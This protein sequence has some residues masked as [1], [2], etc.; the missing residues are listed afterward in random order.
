MTFVRISAGTFMMGSPA[1]ELGRRDDEI[2]H[3]VT[4]TLDFYMQETE[5]TQGQWQ[6]VMGENP[7]YFQNCGENCPVES[8]SWDD[9]Q[10][11][12]ARLNTQ[13]ED[14]YEYRLPTEAQ[15]EY[16]ARADSDTAFYDGDISEPTGND[17][18]LNTLGWYIENSD[19]GYEECHETDN[20]RCIGPQPVRGK[21]PSAW[22]LFDMHGNVWE[23]RSDWYGDYPDDSVND[24]LGPSS[25]AYRVLRGGSWINV[26]RFCR[27]AFRYRYVPGYRNGSLGF[28]LAASLSSR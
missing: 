17:P 15:W 22:G 4:L 1:T 3:E 21:N 26:A 28:R 14:D 7:S 23:W 16:A 27:S 10:E 6:A 12:L 9:V 20:G 11:F 13:I 8:V 24:P 5:E 18:I 25:G 19:A 2:Q